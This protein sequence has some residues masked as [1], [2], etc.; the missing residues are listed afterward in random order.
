VGYGLY[1]TYRFMLTAEY[2]PE[3]VTKEFEIPVIPEVTWAAF[4]TACG[5][6]EELDTVTK[7]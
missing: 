7:I 5:E 4:C 3:G 1:G 2:P 6:K